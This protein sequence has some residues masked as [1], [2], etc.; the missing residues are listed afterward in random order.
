MDIAVGDTI[1]TRNILLLSIGFIFGAPPTKPVVGAI[2]KNS[3]A[4]NAG[5][6]V[7]DTILSVNDKKVHNWDQVMMQLQLIN[8]KKEVSFKIKDVTGKELTIGITPEKKVQDDVVTYHF[9]IGTGTKRERGIMSSLS[10]AGSKLVSLTQS[11][12]TVLGGLFTGKISVNNISGPVGIYTVIGEQAKAG[13]DSILYLTAFL[14]INVGFINL[15]P[16]PAF[17]GGRIL[18]LIIEKIK[19]SPVDAKVENMFHYIGFF[20]LIGLMILVTF[21]DILRLF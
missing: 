18:F 7:G 9:G 8:S 16:F 15:I 13:F 10:Y 6:E 17:D 20:L 4:Y 11:M 21:N 14:S 19:G 1:L 12:G 5:L 3:A 2:E